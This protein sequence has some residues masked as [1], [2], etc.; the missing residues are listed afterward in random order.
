MLHLIIKIR[1]LSQLLRLKACIAGNEIEEVECHTENHSIAN[2][3]HQCTDDTVQEIELELLEEFCQ[4]SGNP[5]Q[6]QWY[7][8]D[9]EHKSDESSETDAGTCL[10]C[11][12]VA[13]LMIECGG[14]EQSDRHTQKVCHLLEGA[15]LETNY[16]TNNQH[17]IDEYIHTLITYF[18][19]LPSLPPQC[20]FPAHHPRECHCS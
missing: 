11:Q 3:T 19:V 14:D 16:G 12:E 6:S 1:T 5:S 4:E 7:D 18:K 13:K 8:D 2:H 17:D 15:L 9:D 20:K 10:V